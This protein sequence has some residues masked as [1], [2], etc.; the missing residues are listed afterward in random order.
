MSTSQWP[1]TF[2]TDGTASLMPA[3][4]RSVVLKRSPSS[5]DAAPPPD[6]CLS[7]CPAA[8][9][10][11]VALADGAAAVLAAGAG[12]AAFPATAA[13]VALHGAGRSRYGRE[14]LASTQFQHFAGW[15]SLGTAS[16]GSCCSCVLLPGQQRERCSLLKHGITRCKA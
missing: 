1:L 7:S 12:A 8:L 2:L 3:R 10:A 13:G 15:L 5:I 4:C 11:A 16:C 6:D 14:Q 9:P